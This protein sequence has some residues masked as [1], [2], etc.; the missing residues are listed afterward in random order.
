MANINITKFIVSFIEISK[1]IEERIRRGDPRYENGIE[2]KDVVTGA[3]FRQGLRIKDGRVIH[4]HTLRERIW[5]LFH[6]KAVQQETES[7]RKSTETWN[8]MID[9]CTDLCNEAKNDV[10]KYGE[11]PLVLD[12]GNGIRFPV[13]HNEG[14]EWKIGFVETKGGDILPTVNEVGE[15][16]GGVDYNIKKV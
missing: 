9:K 5:R 10:A 7:I 4:I 11:K 16:E 8:Q 14:K 3:L 2:V 15:G 6:P 1:E 13:P 12:F